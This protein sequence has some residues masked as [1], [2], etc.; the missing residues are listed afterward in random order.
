MKNAPKCEPIVKIT[1]SPSLR[2]MD[3]FEFNNWKWIFS[4]P[5]LFLIVVFEKSANNVFGFSEPLKNKT[6]I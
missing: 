5:R 6:K 3:G 4:N 2:T 1:R